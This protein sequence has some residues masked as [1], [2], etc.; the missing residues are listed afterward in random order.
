MTALLELRGLSIELATEHGPRLAVEGLDLALAP[1]ETLALVGESGSGKTLTAL[2]VL[3]VLPRAA[4]V[5]SGEIL[6]RGR[7]LLRLEPGARRA[8]NG[9]E[10]ALSFQEPSSAFDPV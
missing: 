1:G 5:V 6:W 9:K 7:D 2:A 4:R 8:L 3:G 10:L